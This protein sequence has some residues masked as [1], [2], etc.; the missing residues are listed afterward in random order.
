MK[1]LPCF[2]HNISQLLCKFI[3]VLHVALVFLGKPRPFKEFG[4]ALMEKENATGTAVKKGK[5][6]GTPAALPEAPRRCWLWGF[7]SCLLVPWLPGGQLGDV[8]KAY[9]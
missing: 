5:G 3:A 6:R 7:P 1:F 9:L 4:K 8:L 2:V